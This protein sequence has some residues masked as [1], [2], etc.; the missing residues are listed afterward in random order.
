M[1]AG[2]SP[3]VIET[4]NVMTGGFPAEYGNRFGG[5]LDVVTKS[6]LRMQND[7]SL[8]ATGG[9]AGR[10][11]LA[12]E[13]GGHGGRFGYYVFGS[14]FQSDRFLSPP[15][16]KAI[17]DRGRGGRLFFQADA[18]LREAGSVRMVLMADGANFQIPNHPRDLEL[19]PRARAKQ[20]TRQES[21]IA[22]WTRAGSEVSIAGSFYQ[23]WSGSRLSPAGD[24]LAATAQLDR[25][26]LTL[27]G[28]LDVTRFIARHAVKAG[29]DI[30]R[31]RP[32][33]VLSYDYAGYRDLTHALGW[34]HIHVVGGPIDFAGRDS[35]GQVSAYIQDGVEIAARVSANVGVRVDRYD[36]AV[37]AT[38]ASPRFN[39]AW[40]IGGDALVHA[41][42]NHFFVPPPVEG[43]LSSNAGLTARVREVGVPLRAIEPTI[44]DQIE[45]GV[46]KPVGPAR[47]AATGYH[48][49]SDNPV[50]TTVWP[51]SRI[52]SYASFD[53]ARAYGLEMKAELPGL[54]RYGMTGYLNYA[55]FRV[56]FYNPVTGGFVAEQATS[57]TRAAFPRLWTRRTR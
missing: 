10:R 2:L 17:H 24:P 39:L 51:D 40:D 25:E 7:G 28:K 14:L 31:L 19:R 47:L 53:R 13:F 34:P 29:V 4:A 1:S 35:G 49:V 54:T 42:Y 18:N 33:E 43:V 6:G 45:F 32:D 27:G 21:A 9:D 48:R 16:R 22:S 23:R 41:S 38:H 26:M 44:E 20:R 55:V 11:S 8:S 30:V 46:S 15:D 5:V 37:S 52:Y 3:M 50:H 36:L 12:G 56:N 57:A